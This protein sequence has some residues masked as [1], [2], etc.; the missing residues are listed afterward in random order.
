MDD[1]STAKKL[2]FGELIK[3]RPFYGTKHHWRDV[4]NNDLKTLDVLPKDWYAST[5]NRQEWYELHNGRCSEV[6]DTQ[7]PS[8]QCI[9][10]VFNCRCG[11][12]FH[13]ASR[14]SDSSFTLL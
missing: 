12:S 5:M 2:L 13:H 7:H 1:K 6:T 10:G 8:V 9:A 4:V 14:R 11:H 3:S